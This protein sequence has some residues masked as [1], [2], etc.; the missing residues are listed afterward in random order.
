[1]HGLKA[2]LFAQK[3]VPNP[4]TQ[5]T[6]KL[7]SPH[8]SK[9]TCKERDPLP[10]IPT[11]K[12]GGLYANKASCKGEASSQ[13][14]STKRGKSP[15]QQTGMH[16]GQQPLAT[17]TSHTPNTACA[18]FL[19][20]TPPH[21]PRSSGQRARRQRGRQR[22]FGSGLAAVCRRLHRLHLGHQRVH[23]LAVEGQLRLRQAAGRRIG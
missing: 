17:S 23:G 10:N 14:T 20:Q 7:G 8:P 13:Q 6:N 3:Y 18:H 11:R 22:G 19:G 21:A 15:S 12:E 1:M 16:G 9:P 2:D 4:P 5:H